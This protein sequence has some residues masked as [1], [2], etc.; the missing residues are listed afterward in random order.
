MYTNAVLTPLACYITTAAY[1]Y[2]LRGYV[3]KTRGLMAL[4]W[5]F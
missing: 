2:S 4:A 1:N 3:R 5:F